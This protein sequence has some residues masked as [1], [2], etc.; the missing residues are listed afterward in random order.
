MEELSFCAFS[1]GSGRLVKEYCIL[2]KGFVAHKSH[3][4][5]RTENSS[6]FPGS[7]GQLSA[8]ETEL[9][10]SFAISMQRIVTD[11]WGNCIDG[12]L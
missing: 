12:E 7:N 1:G 9:G 10:I 2:T 8:K 3:K 5:F 6:G 11:L 4:I